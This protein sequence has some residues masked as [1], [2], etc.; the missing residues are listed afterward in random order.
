MWF[1]TLCQQLSRA[2]FQ[3]VHYGQPM[4]VYSGRDTPIYGSQGKA[5]SRGQANNCKEL[6]LPGVPLVSMDLLSMCLFNFNFGHILEEHDC[7]EWSVSHWPIRVD[8]WPKSLYLYL[9]FINFMYSISKIIIISILKF[10]L[11][12]VCNKDSPL[13]SSG[14]TAWC[15]TRGLKE[16]TLL[17]FEIPS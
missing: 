17:P 10:P 12:L 14:S 5:H 6:Q 3:V 9:Y 8:P 4:L 2:A 1:W 15:R 7:R 11:N 13:P 16:Y